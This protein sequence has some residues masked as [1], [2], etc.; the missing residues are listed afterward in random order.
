VKKFYSNDF[1]LGILGGGQLGRMFVQEAIHYDVRINSMDPAIDAPCSKIVH[2]FVKGDLNDF[3]AVYHFGKSNDVLTIEIENVNTEALK[4]LESEGVKVYPKPDF[5]AMV[6]DKG[7]QKQFYADHNIPTAP[8]ILMKDK[9]ELVQNYDRPCVQKMRTGGYDG[10]GVQ[11][12]RH[13]S[14]LDRAFDCP[15]VIEEL[16]PFTKEIAIIVARNPSGQMTTFPLVEMEF[17]PEANLVE[18][19]FSPAE[20]TPAIADQAK[21]IACRIVE[22]AQFVGILAVEMFVLADGQV[23]VNEMAPRPHNSGHHTIEANITS[24]YE[25]HLR[26]ILDL[27]LGDTT[28]L[29]PAVMIN[30][31][32]EKGYSGPVW[33]E[34]VE[35]MMAESG[36]F[37]H[38]YGKSE[39]RDF[40][41]MGHVTCIHPDLEQA[42]SLA[43]K[44]LSTIKVKS[45]V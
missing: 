35:A 43:R 2:S 36:V 8:F 32:G 25:Q 19:L 5:L 20:V 37:V 31:L 16:V 26:A 14:D 11:V 9:A 44:A 28:T 27:P 13:R 24:Q 34:G 45:T 15:S 29:S 42:K 21:D 40:R 41:K 4:K 17:N 3:D 22:S 33:Y 6:K 1:R 18:F 30:L 7:L 12:L 10:K 38:L 39:T 23:L